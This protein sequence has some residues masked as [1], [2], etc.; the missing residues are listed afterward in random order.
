MSSLENFT[1]L[2]STL[3]YF[4]CAKGAVRDR[5][6]EIERQRDIYNPD[7]ETKRHRDTERQRD[8]TRDTERQRHR[9][10]YI[11]RYDLTVKSNFT[12]GLTI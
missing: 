11:E 8:K 5:N 3:L 7:R 10:T 12:Y 2:Y 4:T 9:E 1:L 6:R